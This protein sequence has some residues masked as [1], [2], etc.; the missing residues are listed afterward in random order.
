MLAVGIGALLAIGGVATAVVVSRGVGADAS[1]TT[2]ATASRD[3]KAASDVPRPRASAMPSAG[4]SVTLVPPVAPPSI[5]P[6]LPDPTSVDFTLEASPAT[7]AVYLGDKKL[8]GPGV[9]HV[10][11]GREKTVLTIKAPGYVSKTVEVVPSENRALPKVTLL[12]ITTSGR[13]SDL[14]KPKW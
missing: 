1:A 14:E 3:T 6:A 12:P 13:P 4:E 2:T 5:P 10:P 11:F 8:G 9:V 7:A